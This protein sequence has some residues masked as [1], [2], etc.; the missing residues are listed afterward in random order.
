VERTGRRLLALAARAGCAA[1]A[2][3]LL[4]LLADLGLDPADVVLVRTPARLLRP[5]A[6]PLRLPACCA[7]LPPQPAPLCRRCFA[8]H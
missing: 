5:P 4:Q 1:L 7:C 2:E 6:C 8:G 3:W